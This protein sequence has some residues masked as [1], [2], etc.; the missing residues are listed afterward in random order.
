[1]LS[2]EGNWTVFEKGSPVVLTTGL[3]MVNEHNRPLL[4]LKRRLR[5]T[6]ES[7]VYSALHEE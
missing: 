7:L 1:M 2:V 4:F 3:T 5:L 6:E